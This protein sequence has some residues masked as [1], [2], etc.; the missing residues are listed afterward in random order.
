MR[1]NAGIDAL[2]VAVGSRNYAYVEV[3]NFDG[4]W[5][6]LGSVSYASRTLY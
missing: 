1:S 3:T 2:R 5:I 4:T 6:N